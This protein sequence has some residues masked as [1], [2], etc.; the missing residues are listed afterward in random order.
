MTFRCLV[1]DDNQR[2]LDAARRSLER[3]GLH[4]VDTALDIDSALE[5]V[6]TG[7]PDVVLVDVSL[8]QESGFD[9][10]RRLAERFSHLTGRIIMISTRDEEDYAELM[11]D[12]SATG[13]LGKSVLSV[14]A[15]RTLIPDLP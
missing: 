6:A 3:Q 12:T 9:L 15:I 2:F 4:A 7:R 8:G 14:Q 11:E 5:A 13:F 1:V 10:V